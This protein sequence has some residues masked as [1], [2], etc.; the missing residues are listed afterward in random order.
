MIAFL[1]H[2]LALGALLMASN[3]FAAPDAGQGKGATEGMNEQGIEEGFQIFRNY[4]PVAFNRIVAIKDG[5][6]SIAITSIYMRDDF[7]ENK[8]LDVIYNGRIVVEGAV[9]VD[10]Y[11]LHLSQLHMS[12]SPRVYIQFSAAHAICAIALGVAREE[13]EDQELLLRK[14]ACA[15]VGEADCFKVH[16]YLSPILHLSGPSEVKEYIAKTYD[17]QHFVRP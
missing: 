12:R 5:S 16:F 8:P 3:A 7:P 2:A 10:Q 15:T 14:C 9:P 17:I 4:I 1:K 11:H 13:S 6:Y